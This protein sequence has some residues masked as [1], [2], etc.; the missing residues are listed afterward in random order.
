MNNFANPKSLIKTKEGNPFAGGSTETNSTS[1]NLKKHQLQNTWIL[2]FLDNNPRKSWEDVLTK[3]GTLSTVEDFWGLYYRIEKPSKLKLGS[4][5]MFFKENIRPMWEDPINLQGGRWLIT[6]GSAFKDDL[7]IIWLDVLLCL[8]GEACDHC[9]Q[10]CGAAVRIRRKVNK[11]SIWT[12][13]AKDEEAILEIGYKLHEV[14]RLV[15]HATVQYHAHK[16]DNTQSLYTLKVFNGP[17]IS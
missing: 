1:Q 8:I 15:S 9:D 6:I 17:F 13:D 12:N 3:I 10:I 2:Y 14:V 5:Y 11:I 7:D 4:D 16:V